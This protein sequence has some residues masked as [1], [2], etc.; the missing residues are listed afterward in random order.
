MLAGIDWSNS[1]HTANSEGEAKHEAFRGLSQGEL[2]EGSTSN[3]QIY[4][5]DTL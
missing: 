3:S 1:S 2:G 5:R 4:I